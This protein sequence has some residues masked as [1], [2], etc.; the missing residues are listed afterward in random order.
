MARLV[1]LNE[2]DAISGFLYPHQNMFDDF[3]SFIENFFDP[4]L[5]MRYDPKYTTFKVD[6]KEDDKTYIV[7]AELPG[8]KKQDVSVD[9]DNKVL[10][11]SVKREVK[12]DEST[13]GFIHRE[14][15]LHSM[16]RAI[17]LPSN[18]SGEAKAK[19]DNG[20]LTITIAKLTSRDNARKVAIE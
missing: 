13:K 7:E 18:L 10:R 6:I 5:G 16:S 4:R 17:G 12:S 19:L 3:G 11:I 2:D 14:R 20:V 8:V 9:L 1:P 15:C